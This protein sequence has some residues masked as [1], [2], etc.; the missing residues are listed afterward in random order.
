MNLRFQFEFNTYTRGG[1]NVAIVFLSDVNGEK[2]FRSWVGLTHGG[3]DLSI[4]RNP[5]ARPLLLDA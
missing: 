4:K 2:T 1:T 5:L 3:A